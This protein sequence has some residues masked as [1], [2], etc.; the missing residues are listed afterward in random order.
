MSLSRLL[1]RGGLHHGSHLHPSSLK[2]SRSC[3]DLEI[4]SVVWAIA[5]YSPWFMII[6]FSLSNKYFVLTGAAGEFQFES[7]QNWEGRG[8]VRQ[9]AGI[10]QQAGEPGEAEEHR[11]D[12][13]VGPPGHWIH[14]GS[15][16]HRH[17]PSLIMLL[18]LQGNVWPRGS[19]PCGDWW[20]SNCVLLLL[21]S[22]GENDS[23]RKNS[24]QQFFL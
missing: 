8:Q 2:R 5:V 20:W 16:G 11:D 24:L 15:A 7:S 19:S 14:A 12:L 17:S 23:V 4:E 10:L 13:R 3:K 1:R 21:S 9:D 6:G 22:N 18:T